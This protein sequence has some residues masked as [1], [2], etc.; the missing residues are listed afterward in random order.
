MN[1]FPKPFSAV[2]IGAS[3]GLGAAFVAS[4]D[5]N[6]SVSN[7]VACARTPLQ[8]N[9]A[10]ITS[11]TLNLEDETSIAAA[12]AQAASMPELRLLIVATGLLHD[13]AVYQPE[14]SMRQLDGARL[15]RAFAINTIGPALIA[16]HF[17]P[18]LPRTGKAVFAALSARVGSISDNRLGGWYGY[19][20]AKAALNM[21]LANLAIET[22]AKR[23]EAIICGLHPGTVDTNLSA[24]F[25]AG[26]RPAKLFSPTVSAAH[27]LNVIDGLSPADT[28]GVFAWDGERV[29]A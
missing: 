6:P 28:G 25:Q 19:R 2:V 16:K 20:A 23:P 26:V 29:E 4:L 3:G 14:K 21:T 12:A 1:S 13:G 18:L 9:S 27:L 10:K 11:R 7:L 22:A 17:L 15:A 5:A 24:P 8:S